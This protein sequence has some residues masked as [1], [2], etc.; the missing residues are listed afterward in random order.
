[1]STSSTGAV[2]T[3]NNDDTPALDVPMV[4]TPP[5]NPLS[6]SP[7]PEVSVRSSIPPT[8]LALVRPLTGTQSLANLRRGVF[9]TVIFLDHED[10]GARMLTFNLRKSWSAFG[11]RFRRI[12]LLE[13]PPEECTTD[14]SVDEASS[15]TF[16]TYRL[17]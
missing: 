10:G 9:Q 6:L 16:D 14:I 1:M 7:S 2:P 8:S 4:A 12:T 11:P 15:V 5:D 17:E 13:A 3:S